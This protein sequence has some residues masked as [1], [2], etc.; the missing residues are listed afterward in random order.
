MENRHTRTL[1]EVYDEML[2]LA[3]ARSATGQ[4]L[5]LSQL[6][7][8][9][10]WSNPSVRAKMQAAETYK[11]QQAQ[12]KAEQERAKKAKTAAG[13]LAGGGGGGKDQPKDRRAVIEAAFDA[14]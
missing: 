9:A 13:S 14:A 5:E 3:Q 11:S 7:D 4:P 6:Y 8:S 12:R 2:A 10:C 1:T